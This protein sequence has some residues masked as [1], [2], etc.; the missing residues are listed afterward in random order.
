MSPSGNNLVKN[1]F[2]IVTLVLS[3]LACNKDAREGNKY[4]VAAGNKAPDFILKDLSGTDI[5]L[6][7][8]SG[9][10]VLL[11]FWATWC[12]PCRSTIPELISLQ[13][14]YKDK[15]I[16]I[17]AVSVDEGQNLEKKLSDFTKENKIN[18]KVLLGTE[19][20]SRA[21]NVRSI[22]VI[23][24]IDRSGVIHSFHTGYEDNFTVK[25]S[26]EIDKLL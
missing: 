25:Y 9:K 21:Y 13:N 16:A 12:P 10:V 1:F 22:P 8:Y 20:M 26:S 19:D 18:Y 15:K 4:P 2:L 23:F 6:L 14:K 7:D 3:L 24:L 11:E 5:K 17:L